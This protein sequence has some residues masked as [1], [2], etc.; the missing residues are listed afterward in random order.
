MEKIEICNFLCLKSMEE[1]K[2]TMK[3]WL[4]L[5]IAF[6]IVFMDIG[7]LLN[8]LNAMT[9]V[10]IPIFFTI[11][12]L[13]LSGL[14]YAISKKLAKH[15][16]YSILYSAIVT[17]L[18][19]LLFYNLFLMFIVTNK[20][21]FSVCHIIELLAFFVLWIAVLV[22]RNFKI[23]FNKKNRSRTSFYILVIPIVLL[24][25]P[26]LNKSLN[27]INESFVLTIAFLLIGGIWMLVSLIYWQNYYYGRKN[28]IDEYYYSLKQNR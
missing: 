9:F 18:T 16:L 21:N 3:S 26:I 5:F 25:T 19:A 2:N 6:T 12:I 24:F 1:Q 11:L 7:F 14:Y 8:F 20:M 22:Y 4:G 10:P 15:I 23:Q 28:S 27:G 17:L 13:P